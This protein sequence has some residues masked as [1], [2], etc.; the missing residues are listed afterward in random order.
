VGDVIGAPRPLVAGEFPQF[1]TQHL[2]ILAICL[3]GCVL[4]VRLGRRLRGSPREP[5]VR[6][7]L[8]V[9]VIAFSLPT[10]LGQ[11]AP[12]E[13]PF[14]AALPFQLCDLAWMVAAY[15]LLVGGWRSRA[16]LY[17]WGLTLSTQ[18]IVTP[19]LEHLWP[20]PMFVGFW[21]LH[22]CTL[23]AAVYLCLG[24]GRGPDWRGYRWALACTYAWAV[25]MMVFNAVV[26]TNYGFVNSKPPSASILNVLGPW[27]VYVLVEG[28][29][30]ASVWA[31]IT[32][33]WVA[34][35]HSGAPDPSASRRLRSR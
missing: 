31:L 35:G 14:K 29:I 11:F 13:G 1:G 21:G 7:A 8:G 9:A 5:L 2:V 25:A 24:L 34:A 18:A 22:A 19:S 6:R 27:P 16:L 12:G 17:F 15:A 32:W 20:D 23:W 3:V 26:G 10:Q 30:I 28:A 33:P 4:L